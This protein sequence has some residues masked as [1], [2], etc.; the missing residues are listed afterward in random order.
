MTTPKNK[1]PIEESPSDAEREC[2]ID[3]HLAM[4]DQTNGDERRRNLES[5][6]RLIRGRSPQ[7]WRGWNPSDHAA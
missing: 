6:V 7:R 2:Q 1:I 3:H 4:L 5:M